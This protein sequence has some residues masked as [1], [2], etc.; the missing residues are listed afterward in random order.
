M[1]FGIAK[2]LR[3]RCERLRE[4]L[5]ARS[6]GSDQEIKDLWPGSKLNP[7]RDTLAWARAYAG[8][9]RIAGRSERPERD[10]TAG[11]DEAAVMDAIADTP[12]ELT[13][14]RADGTKFQV[15]VYAKSHR[16]LEWI[17]SRG[18]R[19]DWLVKSRADLEDSGRADIFDLVERIGEEIVHQYAL[20]AEAAT[21]PGCWLPWE[22]ADVPDRTQDW[23]AF[24]SPVDLVRIKDAF[25]RVNAV[26][27]AVLQGRLSPRKADG[28]PPLSWA[29]FFSLRGSDTG[30][31]TSTLLR[32]RSLV[33]E[34]AA[35][36]M[37]SSARDRT[38]PETHHG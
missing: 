26:R 13:I 30:V 33:S 12:E 8:L 1:R 27:L 6:A 32:D 38:S 22:P 3:D 23:A 25:I 31:A 4:H 21:T 20:L 10:R 19:I 11:A 24:V 14:A 15:A 16:A 28:T 17:G 37:A 34:V 36:L 18:R 29:E 35:A 9:S 2:E 5:S 7:K